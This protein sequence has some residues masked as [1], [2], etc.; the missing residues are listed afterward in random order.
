MKNQNTVTMTKQEL[1]K[2]FNG[3]VHDEGLIV[4]NPYSQE[5]YELNNTELSMYDFIV[6]ANLL[7]QKGIAPNKVVTNMQNGLT[8][9]RKNNPEAYMAL[10]D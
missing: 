3:I 1:P 10:L 8:W 5:E 9:F 4:A 6:G 2:W 7:Y